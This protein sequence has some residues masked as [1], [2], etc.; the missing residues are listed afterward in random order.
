VKFGHY[1]FGYARDKPSRA[2]TFHLKRWPRAMGSQVHMT[3]QP[4]TSFRSS[5]RWAAQLPQP[6]PNCRSY[7][8]CYGLAKFP[9]RVGLALLYQSARGHVRGLDGLRFGWVRGTPSEEEHEFHGNCIGASS[10]R[11]LC[12]NTGLVLGSKME[13]NYRR[14]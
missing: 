14:R 2:A 6:G 4:R 5:A 11:G 8:H 9:V 3:Q 1:P 13:P 12:S 7:F 10:I